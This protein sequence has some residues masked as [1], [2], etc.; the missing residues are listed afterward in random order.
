MKKRNINNNINLKLGLK[1][2]P[3]D[4]KVGELLEV[5]SL[6]KDP[7]TKKGYFEIIKGFCVQVLKSKGS[8]KIANIIKQIRFYYHFQ[9]NSKGIRE[10]RILKGNKLSLRTLKKKRLIIPK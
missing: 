8:I 10:I 7:L 6:K 4:F 3:I 5:V 9:L 2:K 1:K